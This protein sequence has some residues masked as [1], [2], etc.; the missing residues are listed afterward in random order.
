M[1][2]HLLIFFKVPAEESLEDLLSLQD[3]VLVQLSPTEESEVGCVKN[4]ELGFDQDKVVGGLIA[5][6]TWL[7]SSVD[8]LLQRREC[9]HISVYNLTIMIL[10]L[11]LKDNLKLTYKL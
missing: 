1:Y 2:T 4:V 11:Q 5:A 10:G 7:E 9:H 8:V 6:W 3:Q